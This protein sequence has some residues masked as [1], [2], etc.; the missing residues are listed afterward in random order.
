MKFKGKDFNSKIKQW[1]EFNY[2]IA[3]SD[4][5]ASNSIQDHQH[6]FGSGIIDHYAE[7]RTWEYLSSTTCSSEKQK[8]CNITSIT[9]ANESKANYKN[10]SKDKFLSGI[11]NSSKNLY[12]PFLN[13]GTQLYKCSK[14]PITLLPT[15]HLEF[16]KRSRTVARRYK[17]NI[18]DKAYASSSSLNR[19]VRTHTG[20]TPYQCTECDKCFPYLYQLRDHNYIHT[21]EKPYS[22]GQCGKSFP[23]KDILT[24]HLRIHTGENHSRVVN[25]V[26]AF[27]SKI[28]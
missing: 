11:A 6:Y 17:C 2:G 27:L 14:D 8:T 13:V 19:H 1:T 21:G 3:D 20:D 5:C 25:V 10:P 12:T 7:L 18:C 26:K 24:K 28:V 4:S 16:S 22:C 9:T 23:F 15:D